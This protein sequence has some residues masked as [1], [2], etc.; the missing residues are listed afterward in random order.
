MNDDTRGG[1][2]RR[3]AEATSGIAADR[4]MMRID[5]H[6]HT[7]ASD[8]ID[9]VHQAREAIQTFA[10]RNQI[11][12]PVIVAHPGHSAFSRFIQL[13]PV[14]DKKLVEMIGDLESKDVRCL[15][16]WHFGWSPAVLDAIRDDRRTRR[17]ELGA[18]LLNEELRRRY[19]TV[20]RVGEFQLL[21]R[22]A[23]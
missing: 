17:P 4:P 22:R 5:P 6:V 3:P 21:E 11:N 19:R 2:A 15:V 14:D 9:D 18:T 20:E 7:L 1:G 16:L 10:S 12:A 23:R 8:G 13:P